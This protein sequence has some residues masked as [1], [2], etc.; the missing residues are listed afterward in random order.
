MLSILIL[1]GCAVS[2][3]QKN[4]DDLFSN[5]P[6]MTVKVINQN[7]FKQR[8][9][10]GGAYLGMHGWIDNKHVLMSVPEDNTLNRNRPLLPKGDFIIVDT[11]T[12]EIQPLNWKRDADFVRLICIR[13]GHVVYAQGTKGNQN[14]IFHKGD[15]FGNF[16]NFPPSKNYPWPKEL[17]FDTTNCS[18]LAS[19]LQT[20]GENTTI[21]YLL[22]GHGWVVDESPH[23]AQ[24]SPGQLYYINPNL[25]KTQ[26]PVTNGE[27]EFKVSPYI[28]HANAY[29][30]T[31]ELHAGDRG[32]IWT[33]HYIRLL[34]PGGEITSIEVPDV[35]MY[36]LKNKSKSNFSIHVWNLTVNGPIW[37]LYMDVNSETS[38]LIGNY[39]LIG[40][41]L[42]RIPLVVHSISPDGCKILGTNE[43]DKSIVNLLSFFQKLNLPLNKRDYSVVNLCEK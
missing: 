35:L 20:K 37:A 13:E 32:H 4:G 22:S 8:V 34:H 1:S 10:L 21:R 24:G 33:L 23:R 18:L 17:Y 9:F 19:R 5:L 12:G 41:K 43:I 7:Q 15:I 26:I 29:M 36:L 11:E 16:E 27:R 42:T 14:N 39:I 30:I 6:S 38:K 31:P 25:E 40:D 2:S 3:A 28:S